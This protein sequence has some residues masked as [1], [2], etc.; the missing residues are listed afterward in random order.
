[1]RTT[2]EDAQRA[3]TEAALITFRKRGY[4][5]ATLEEIGARVNLTR[6]AVLHHFKS[7]SGLLAAVVHPCRQAL[8]GLLVPPPQDDPPTPF[9]RRQILTRLADVFLAHRDTLGLLANDVSARAQLGLGDQ[10]F[11]PPGQLVSLLVGTRTNQEAGVRVAAAIGA[12]LQP[13]TWAWVDLDNAPA[14]AELI[15]AA[16]SV[17]HGVPAPAPASRIGPSPKAGATGATRR[18]AS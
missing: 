10:W 7:K 12:L 18:A 14:R 3:I 16:V 5:P 9:A 4:A 13:V 2:S 17:L 6:G 15:E 11:M 1:M 8:A